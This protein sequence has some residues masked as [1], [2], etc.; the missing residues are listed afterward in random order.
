MQALDAAGDAAAAL[1]GIKYVGPAFAICALAL[2]YCSAYITVPEQARKLLE[3]CKGLLDDL[4]QAWPLLQ[5][6]PAVRQRMDS[7]VEDICGVAERYI[8]VQSARS[9][10]CGRLLR[11]VTPG[12]CL[13]C[14]HTQVCS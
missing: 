8:Q 12:C 5:E 11:Y 6:D 10:C 2:Q 4:V 13:T 7:W 3:T 9:G 14:L 1:S